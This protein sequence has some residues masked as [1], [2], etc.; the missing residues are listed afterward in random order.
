MVVC[1]NFV[2]EAIVYMIIT[3]CVASLIIILVLIYKLNDI[4]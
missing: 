3:L 1:S 4:K 2:F